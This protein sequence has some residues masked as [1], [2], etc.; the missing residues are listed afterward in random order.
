M[1]FLGIQAMTAASYL[2]LSPPSDS[3][4]QQHR[5][6]LDQG[7]SLLLHPSSGSSSSSSNDWVTWP[8]VQHAFRTLCSVD[9][10]TASF[11]RS[12]SIARIKANQI[13]QVEKMLE[14]M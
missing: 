9:E 1:A 6:L 8:S 13:K 2:L 7:R 10:R 11:S 14:Y 5:S 4:D 12:L 3:T